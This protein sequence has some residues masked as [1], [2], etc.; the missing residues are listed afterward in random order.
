[1]VERSC[2]VVIRTFDKNKC[3]LHPEGGSEDAVLAEMNTQALVFGADEDGADDV[4][5]SSDKV[6]T[7]VS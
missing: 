2:L 3:Q 6:Q 5:S 4:A 7:A 1:M